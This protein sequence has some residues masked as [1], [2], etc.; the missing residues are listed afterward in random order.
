MIRNLILTPVSA[1]TIQGLH[2]KTAAVLKY[3]QT[4]LKF[5]CLWSPELS[6]SVG[7]YFALTM[8]VTLYGF[9]SVVTVLLLQL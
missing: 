7:Q 1:L 3:E 9:T 4:K 6:S 8:A 2:I 5:F